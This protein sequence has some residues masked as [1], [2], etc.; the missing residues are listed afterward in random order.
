M[1]YQDFSRTFR[2]RSGWAK[3]TPAFCVSAGKGVALG[4][5]LALSGLQS[6]K[7][8][9]DDIEV[10]IN[11]NT[12]VGPNVLFIFDLSGSMA[13]VPDEDR[14][15]N[16]GE[17]TRFSVL[18]D[19]LKKTLSDDLGALNIG[20]SWYGCYQ[21]SAGN[22]HNFASG[23]KWPVTPNESG[24]SDVDPDIPYGKSVKT[25]IRNIMDAQSPN[26]GTPIV[27]ALFEAALY[28]SGESVTQGALTPE[29][30]TSS[31]QS[32]TGTSDHSIG[33]AN[34]YSY[35]PSD[36]FDGGSGSAHYISPIQ[37]SC[38]PNYVVLLT[39]GRPTHLDYQ[40]QIESY[41]GKTC[42]DQSTGTGVMADVTDWAN[43][44]NCGIELADHMANNSLVPSIP[45]S[46]VK[47]ITIG[48]ALG[49]TTD[50]E[51]GRKFLQAL[52][53]AGDGTF[54]EVTETLD[55]AT[56]LSTIVGQVSGSNESFTPPS[57]SVNPA[58]LAT[59][60]RSFIGMFKPAHNRAWQGNLKGYFLGNT[61]LLDVDGNQATITGTD[62]L[63]FLS[64]ARSFWS[65]GADGDDVV[66]GGA[67]SQLTA[68]TRNLYTWLGSSTDLTDASNAIAK[69]NAAITATDY[70]MDAEALL[71]LTSDDMVDWLQSAPLG[72][73]LHSQPVMVNYAS[74]KV[75]YVGTNQGF[76]H[77]ID[78]TTPTAIKDYT[79][80][81]ELF[82]FMPQE[83]LG[84]VYSLYRN[85]AWGEHIYGMDGDITIYHDDDNNDG[86]VNGSDTVTLIAGM[87]RGGQAY[88][89]LDVTDPTS[90]K[91]KWKI[92]PSES[93]YARLGQSWSRPVLTTIDGQKVLIFGGGYDPAQDD[94]TSRSADSMGNAV[95]IAN[96]DTGALIWSVSSATGGQV[97]SDMQYAI[98]SALRVV[99]MDANGSADRIY[100][101]DMGG[102]LWRVDIDE[103]KLNSSSGATVTRLANFNNGSTSGNRKFFYPPA[104]AI[105]RHGADEFLSVAIGSGNRSHPLGSDVTNRIYVYQDPHVAKGAPTSTVSTVDESDLFD[106]TSN[107]ISEGDATTRSAAEAS[108]AAKQGWYVSLPTARKILSEGLI[109]NDAVMF[110]AY[111]PANANYDP[112][113]APE[114]RGY[115]VKMSVTDGTPTDNLD[116]AGDEDSLKASDRYK[117]LDASGIPSQPSLSFPVSENN[118]EVYVGRQLVDDMMQPVTKMFW[119]VQE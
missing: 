12:S 117:Y 3:A 78:A 54:Y 34:R 14:F 49:S 19:A 15:A 45:G 118:V 29:N 38:Q 36:A 35:T 33:A 74:Q 53:D 94:K 4:A 59:D 69:A 50:A 40:S 87:R 79:G 90:P 47:T 100:F 18:H 9:A 48:F 91:Y 32:Y 106:A 57:I 73:P 92:S 83:L 55:L 22:Y 101:G 11:S 20:L 115:F 43:T 70:G 82:A 89:A 108:L 56:I 51:A 72:D 104:V 81:S 65:G 116:G 23:I 75:I 8:Q 58:K 80:G 107:S 103:T 30:W 110:S 76:V 64:T 98:P 41:L 17:D 10:Y 25:V 113:S 99:D 96:A 26:G 16:P 60:D 97:K 68:G 112:C 21:D 7:V 37:S 66:T 85:L 71:T 27:D 109:Y 63:E 114:S 105:T 52:A 88:Y 86:I 1:W 119:R 102:Q 24:A 31:V 44:A 77:A 2:K 67:N 95:Y 13:Y 39:D 61:G 62:G 46:S 5:V 84:N 6:P 42:V 111:E 28:F 93:G